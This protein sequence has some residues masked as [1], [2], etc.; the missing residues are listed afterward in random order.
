[1]GQIIRICSVLALAGA[2][3][4][5]ALAK[6]S[7]KAA[8]SALK[9][10]TLARVAAQ[11]G[12]PETA[13]VRY[14][15][16]LA[17]DKTNQ[18]Y[19]MQAFRVALRQGDLKF[20][21][22]AARQLS[23][24]SPLPFDVQLTLLTDRIKA[25]DW[26]GA[27]ARVAQIETSDNLKFMVPILRAWIAQ[28]TKKATPLSFFEGL[29]AQSSTAVYAPEHRA[30]LLMAN[31]AEADALTLTRSL[32]LSSSGFPALRLSTASSLM[33]AGKAESALSLL[34]EEQI[35]LSGARR[36]AQTNPKALPP[37]VRTTAQGVAQFFARI[38]SDLLEN[39][40][41]EFALVLA[42][43]ARDLD[44]DNPFVGL[45]E[46]RALDS[47]DMNIAAE[48]RYEILS[49]DTVVADQAREARV[50][51]LETL[52]RDEEAIALARVLAFEKGASVLRMVNLG[53]LM[54]RAGRYQEAGQAYDSA[55]QTN[56][57]GDNSVETWALWY[58]K[59]TVLEREKNWP[60]A[61]AAFEKA[62]TLAPNQAGPLNH[63]GYAML[64]RRIELPTA[65][66]LTRRATEL[67]PGDA[68]IADSYGW[69]LYLNGD[70]DR[71]LDVL[72][73]AVAAEPTEP[74][75]GEHLGDVYW[76][77]GRQIEARYA[78]QAAS[79]YAEK[80]ALVRLKDKM[81]FGMTSAKLK[82]G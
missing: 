70:V 57:A 65:L 81:D 38:S 53:D 8:P 7:T 55:L 32:V 34:G 6:K 48:Q 56:L 5:P 69:A 16:A 45:A 66:A 22:Q 36:V 29:P 64:E 54:S 76:A 3:A 15:R 61:R 67:R 59:G 19:A 72:E 4:S 58:L 80:D 40:S 50:E 68:S 82:A 47:V 27:E 77:S 49:R 21:A 14:A 1:V 74:T 10:Y 12:D 51:L 25:A 43:L 52:N 63:L 73:A 17:I 41:P 31:G 62:I 20:A 2:L 24:T 13:L 33:R 30:Y 79:I 26:R 44:P 39:R 37:P 9:D 71:A 35:E 46:A 60:A 42:R 28:S 23:A 75:L 11:S 78:W 18:T